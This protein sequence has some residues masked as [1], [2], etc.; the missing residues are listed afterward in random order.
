MRRMK[1]I[2]AI[3]LAV[4]LLC[5]TYGSDVLAVEGISNP[6]QVNPVAE[7]ETDRAGNQEDGTGIDET[8]TDESGAAEDGAAGGASGQ[9]DSGTIEDT[10]DG[11]F[12]EETDGTGS[13]DSEEETDAGEDDA[14]AEEDTD[15]GEDDVSAEEDTDGREDDAPAEEDTDGR[16]DDASTEEDTDEGEPVL[17][18][19][20]ESVSD[21]SISISENNLPR[22][23]AAGMETEE[24]FDYTVDSKTNTVTLNGYAT[25]YVGGA[26]LYIPATLG[27]YPVTEIKSA[28]FKK[29]I[30]LE[31]VV[32]PDSVETIGT[33]AFMDCAILSSV[34]LPKGLKSMG[35]QAFQ[36]CVSLT[37]IEIPKSLETGQGI[38]NPDYG[39][40]RGCDKLKNVTFEE[41]TTRIVKQL[42]MGCASLEEITIPDT[43]TTIEYMAFERC[44][45][46]RKVSISDSV[47]EIGNDAFKDCTGLT[48]IV[49]PDSVTTIGLH[50]F[51]GCTG[52]AEVTLSRN[53]KTMGY[54]TF[55]DCTS[56]TTIEIPKSLE[57][58]GSIDNGEYG[59]FA[60]CEKLKSVTFE[61]GATRIADHLFMGCTSLEEIVIPDTVTV[62]EY[63]AFT[64]CVNL[65]KVTIPNSVS[66]IE[67]DAF[68]DCTGMTA[69]TLPDSVTT[70]GLHV[71]K[72]C[73]GLAEVT[74]S[75]NLKTMGY[76]T[77]KGCTSL[78]TIEIPKSLESGGSIDNGEYGSFAGC[79]KLKSITFEEGVTRI[80]DH[81]LMGCTSLEEIIIPDTVTVIERLAFEGCTNLTHISIPASVTKIESRAFRNCTGMTGIDLSD[82][83][84]EI[85]NAALQGCT[86][87]T[88]IKVPESVRSLGT[89]LLSGCLSLEKAYLGDSVTILR[90]NTFS[91]CTKLT[92]LHLPEG[93]LTVESS[94][95]ANCDSLPEIILPEHVTKVDTRAFFDC[96]GL[97]KV[98]IPDSV[99]S[100]GTYV[101]AECE[102]LCDVSLGTGI[103][104]I[105]SYGF[106]LCPSLQKIVL[107]YRVATIKSNAFKDCAQFT[108]ITIPRATTVIEN[109]A[110]SYP[111]KLTIYGV[112]GTYA[113]TY[114]ASV[115]ATFVNLEKKAT[116]VH[117]DKTEL[118]LGNGK[119]TKLIL[120]V[121]PADFTDEVSWKSS[122]TKVVTVEDTGEVTAKSLGTATVKVTVG[123]V[124]ASCKITVKQLVT[125][126]SLNKTSLSLDAGDT[127]K[128]TASVSP[129]TAE[130]KSVVW[131]TSDERIASVD[132]D[133]LVTAHLKGTAVVRVE[134]L[135]DST[136]YRECN[137]EVKGNGYVCDTVDG[138]ES[139]HNYPNNCSDIW[140]YTK[141]GAE[142][143][144]VSFDSRTTVEEEFDYIYIFDGA[145]KQIG[146]YTGTQL[147]GE[148]VEVP[149]D[150]V[151]IR[152]VSDDKT[153]AW[154]FKVTR[155]MGT[156]N[157]E[158]DEYQVT[159]DTQGGTMIF[160]VTV[161]KNMTV[162]EPAVPLKPG[163]KFVGWYLDGK[164]YDF[165]RPVTGNIVLLAR[166]ERDMTGSGPIEEA[167]IPEEDMPADGVVPDG[168]WIA[169]VK[170]Q[171]YT[172]KAHKPEVHVYDGRVRLK[173]KTDYT[174]SYKN[175]TKA[176]DASDKKT[177]PTITVK[178]KG[179]YAG[180]A[181]ATFVI[182]PVNIE[183]QSGAGQSTIEQAPAVNIEGI[184]L[185]F[186]GKVQQKAPTVTFNGKKLSA[187]RDYTV[188]Y[189]DTGNG[190]YQE[191]GRYPVQVT[192]VG[193]FTG[194]RTVYLEI[195]DK[196]LISKAKVVRIPDKP[197]HDGEA[198]MLTSSELVLY[199]KSRNEPL[200]E[201][202]DYE[203]IDY[204]N[205]Q[206][207]GTATAVIQ[208]MGSYAGTKKVTYK[209]VGTSINKAT[210]EG[211]ANSVYNGSKQEPEI[212]VKVN[213]VTLVPDQHY[214]VTYNQNQ[215]VGTASVVIQGVG[216]YT[217][218]VKKKF[219][220]TPYDLEKDEQGLITNM[221]TA[222]VVKYVKGGCKPQ[223]VL[224]FGETELING[225]DYTV[226]YQYNQNI[227]D[228]S[229]TKAPTM[230]I[231]GKGN[232]KGTRTEKFTI[233][234]KR[235]TDA[236]EPVTVST[237]D[238][239]Y[240]KGA[241]KYISKP[242]LTDVDGK[243]LKAGTDYDVTY[244]LADGITKLNKKSTVPAG[245][246][247]CVTVK[248]KGKYEGSLM[249]TYRITQANFTK[250]TVKI[251]AQTYTGS[252]IYLD[253]ETGGVITVKAGRTELTYGEDYEILEDS[254]VNNI[255]KGTA[256][257]KIRGIHNYGGTKTVNFKIQAKKM[258][259]FSSIIKSILSM[260]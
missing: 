55:K 244:T 179:N 50:V 46:L 11:S 161:E 224:R 60:G 247:V 142:S 169:G 91:D 165:T 253:G 238:I 234:K 193:N 209:I 109:N 134:A 168:L 9:P 84:T 136:V 192:G 31:T 117:L 138:L 70:I 97:T 12:G 141:E 133:G 90:T 170:D 180:S 251:A 107:P 245:S 42:F 82:G 218:T 202:T 187:K 140:I 132:A 225:T 156:G 217:G 228:A 126:I 191:T 128:L 75:R 36:N 28:A 73:T 71:F 239:A 35:Y 259:S 99:T 83:L 216:A 249:T 43:V 8:G 166:W 214:T 130:N 110:F 45:N 175:N 120:S 57:S 19:D 242:V 148:T 37:A 205:N 53:L 10:E 150:T 129:S 248:G 127:E 16:E 89:E 94:A 183:E 204:E 25:G 24:N 62:I 86:G 231:K 232:F 34:T 203:V 5:G 201:G 6:D 52:L 147:A 98:I 7:S 102:L 56:L 44:V 27:G 106:N 222:S 40:F 197:Y 164:P 29:T 85:G 122:D 135:D 54:E 199:I 172:G 255:R 260:R 154:G 33:A 66:E 185:A 118:K 144:L 21:N 139:P 171:T 237:A 119:K 221:M 167:P 38:D 93:L 78:T 87:L 230:K 17:P 14:P 157:V 235:L 47:T 194:T 114:A 112:S 95:F 88:E 123:D 163:F 111:L 158:N 152:L 131:S 4:C 236:E 81:L 200:S 65:K 181:T 104:T 190:A 182:A 32:I 195:T 80:A 188:A 26:E 254:Y 125:S 219:K 100:L 240:S 250:V 243:V 105:P 113:E 198:I 39:M 173:E 258:E 220:I 48:Q 159:F 51:K 92:D 226:A 233:V 143:L 20:G 246:Y 223:P 68:R 64:S 137:V 76:E 146:K 121:T 2:L 79:E 41:G 145:K 229:A 155:V 124:S 151:R 61:D 149:G 184:I 212:T 210:V 116:Q 74:L 58:G 227:A 213:G 206:E 96:D 189:P 103:T 177:A 30:L 153:S 211:I 174:V 101:F 67:N 13:A 176:N 257:V 63:M 108:E 69:L 59:S 178:G 115:G 208:G 49:L 22:Y 207:I 196:L 1:K 72:G 186:N 18:E 215:N 241:G 252:E 23:N 256:S 160:P 3:A 77:F 15:E 162:S